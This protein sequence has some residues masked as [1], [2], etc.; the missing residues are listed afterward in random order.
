MPNTDDGQQ[1]HYGQR[2]P[3]TVDPTKLTTEAVERTEK[4]LS[5]IFEAKLAGMRELYTEKLTTLRTQIL[6]RD[7]IRDQAKTDANER[8]AAALQAQKEAVGKTE[9]SFGEQ[10]RSMATNLTTL[11]DGIRREISDLKDRI[12]MGEGQKRGGHE[13]ASLLM[14]LAALTASVASIIVIIALHH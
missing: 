1:D 5:L 14:S 10:M 3:P 11:A 12:T 13:N 9:A 8:I 7:L 6:E 4:F 2:P